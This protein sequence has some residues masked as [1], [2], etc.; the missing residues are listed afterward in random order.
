MLEPQLVE[1]S[2]MISINSSG[3]EVIS[4]NGGQIVSNNS[5]CGDL[6]KSSKPTV[7]CNYCKNHDILRKPAT[8]SMG[9]RQ[10]LISHKAKTGME[11]SGMDNMERHIYLMV[12]LLLTRKQVSLVV[13]RLSLAKKTMTG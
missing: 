11:A 8:N 1:G 3:K 13:K 6:P 5:R 2:A 10:I 4:S 7:W 12:R 9:D